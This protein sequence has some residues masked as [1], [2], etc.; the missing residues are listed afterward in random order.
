MSQAAVEM[1]HQN[2]WKTD[3]AS[4]KNFLKAKSGQKV[5]ERRTDD[6]H[7]AFGFTMI[8]RGRVAEDGWIISITFGLAAPDA[9]VLIDEP[10]PAAV[11]I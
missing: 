9:L 4:R 5:R 10:K 8:I 2:R 11:V 1:R 3:C 6:S 7:R